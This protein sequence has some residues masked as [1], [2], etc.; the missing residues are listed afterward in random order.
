MD[1]LR[2]TPTSSSRAGS[3][4]AL[5]ELEVRHRYDH[6]YACADAHSEARHRHRV[7]AWRDRSAASASGVDE[8]RSAK[9]PVA[10]HLSSSVSGAR[11]LV[12]RPRRNAFLSLLTNC[13]HTDAVTVS[14]KD[15]AKSV[16]EVRAPVTQ[17][18]FN[19]YKCSGD[20]WSRMVLAYDHMANCGSVEIATTQTLIHA[21][22]VQAFTYWRLATGSEESHL[23]FR[24]ALL[25]HYKPR[26]NR[27]CG[28]TGADTLPSTDVCASGPLCA[29]GLQLDALQL[30]VQCVQAADVHRLLRTV[31]Q[32]ERCLKMK[33]LDSKS[34]VTAA[35]D[36]QSALEQRCEVKGMLR[37]LIVHGESDRTCDG[38]PNLGVTGSRLYM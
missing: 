25:R 27:P 26:P 32:R 35:Q 12:L 10:T 16:A 4:R 21:L 29:Q 31:A 3:L 9:A 28:G 36:P 38:L 19:K 33:W 37:V 8:A 13:D 17:A 30:R 6:R 2:S 11:L 34:L 1:S 24:Y 14:R 5:R 7:L 23:A 18:L 20:M 22:T 15:A